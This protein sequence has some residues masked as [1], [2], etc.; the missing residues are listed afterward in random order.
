MTIILFQNNITA[1]NFVQRTETW[2][3]KV[4][5]SAENIYLKSWC[6]RLLKFLQLHARTYYI[7]LLSTASCQIQ[8]YLCR[9]TDFS[10]T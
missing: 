4:C 3:D 9:D 2:P 7:V 1:E 8:E 6:G 5:P 10:Q